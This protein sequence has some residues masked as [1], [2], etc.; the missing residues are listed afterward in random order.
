MSVTS[1]DHTASGA[2]CSSPCRP[3]A[4]ER[5]SAGAVLHAGDRVLTVESS[6]PHQHRWIV[7]FAGVLSREAAEALHGAVLRAEPLHDPEALW[8][9]DL[10]GAE[11][12]TPD[13]RTWGRVVAVQANPAHDQLE[14]E[15]GELVP[16][17]FVVDDSRLPHTLVVD[18]PTGLLED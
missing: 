7:Q 11:V 6:R 4:T 1:T 15:S 8:V 18:P 3:T 5:V 12:V 17:V 2:R 10:V 9:H 16:V 14:L 13:G